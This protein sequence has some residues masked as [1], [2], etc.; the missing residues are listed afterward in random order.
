MYL[1]VCSSKK[2]Y[3]FSEL[4]KLRYWE[5]SNVLFSENSPYGTPPESNHSTIHSDANK[6]KKSSKFWFLKPG[7]MQLMTYSP[8][9]TIASSEAT[10]KSNGLKKAAKLKL[11]TT[12]SDNELERLFKGKD[13]RSNS[14][15]GDDLVKEMAVE[16]GGGGGGDGP[17][18]CE[19]PAAVFKLQDMFFEAARLASPTQPG[20]RGGLV[21]TP[22]PPP[23]A[24]AAAG[25]DIPRLPHLH[26]S[27]YDSCSP[28]PY[29]TLTR[30]LNMKSEPRALNDVMPFLLEDKIAYESL[31][32]HYA[33]RLFCSGLVLQ[34][35]EVINRLIPIAEFEG[36]TTYLKSLRN[37]TR[38]YF[39][40]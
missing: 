26:L 39:R 40:N 14:L 34:R 31:K 6:Q 17:V 18:G 1:Y 16:A 12:T 21:S 10:S 20:T 28:S 8:Y 24:A 22:S 36:L 9:H 15:L 4:G 19:S 3:Y 2:R 11:T 32:L 13:K 7:A 23:V 30:T 37:E 33:N 5:H 29:E 25:Q 38:Y 35:C 27:K